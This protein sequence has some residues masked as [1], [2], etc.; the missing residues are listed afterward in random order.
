VLSVHELRGRIGQALEFARAVAAPE[1]FGVP[2]IG[3]PAGSEIGLEVLLEAAGDGIWA[4]GTAG[5]EY[6]GSC[7]R[8]LV[9]IADDGQVEFEELFY[10]PERGDAEEDASFVVAEEV[11]L[12][13]TVRDA[14]LTEL[15]F[16]PLCQPDCLGLC[17]VCGLNLN[18]HPDH[19]HEPD[20]DPRW[21]ALAGWGAPE[22]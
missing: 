20:A 22:G 19:H 7:A 16:T 18:E 2:L 9:E 15:P 14:I 1:G 11:D 21:D 13:D 17:P 8:C 4:T 6:A 10:F 3:V 12:A 5:F